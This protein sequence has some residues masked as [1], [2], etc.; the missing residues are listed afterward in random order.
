M[1]ND[2]INI[3]LSVGTLL[4]N[5]KYRI[6]K[7]LSSGGF[8]N[9]YVVTNLYFEEK[10]AMKE[11]FM[12]GINE[13]DE[14]N[15][16]ISISNS[17]NKTQFFSQLEKFKKEARR[18]RKLSNPHIVRVHDLFEENGTAY[19]IM[20]FIE[21]ESLSEMIKRTGKA[22]R[23]E[24]VTEILNQ[25]I[26]ALDDV[27]KIG[28]WHLDLK[29]AN[30]L[31][32]KLGKIL[33]ID[34]GA[35]KQISSDEGYTSTTT[36]MSYTRGYA[37]TEQ[38]EQR[39]DNIGP[40][41][42]FYALGATL[43]YLLT[44]NEPP[45]VSQL[46]DSDA[47]VFPQLISGRM[48]SLIR[49][50][51]QPNRRKRPQSVTEIRD[52][53]KNEEI[54]IE[55]NK[56]EESSEDTI[57]GNAQ[58][59]TNNKKRFV[60]SLFN[61]MITKLSLNKKNISS[62]HVLFFIISF[63]STVIIGGLLPH[64]CGRVAEMDA[65]TLSL[66]VD[67][68]TIGHEDA[69]PHNLLIDINYESALGK[70]NYIGPVD[71]NHKPHGDGEAT[72]IDGRFYRGPFEHGNFDGVDAYFRYDNGDTFEGSFVNNTFSKGKYTIKADGSYFIG[73]FKNGQPEKGTWYNIDGKVINQVGGEIPQSTF[74]YNNPISEKKN[75]IRG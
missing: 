36:S 52:F 44:R 34:F 56:A 19:Y 11:F 35:S 2:N 23:E 45:T 30:I 41:T 59:V 21:G 48:Q 3:M 5:G 74:K 63:L 61:G 70:C 38:I 68:D 31:Q 42:D 62:T 67:E 37:P 72:F 28:I 65:D 46:L 18:L 9:T 24:N 47:F 33:L 51:M 49:W 66:D 73:T 50:M 20:D 4:Q 60:D 26:D 7:Q 39:L 1:G 69:S 58:I 53:L 22:L 57:L 13:R 55:S 75:R 32:D 43:Y 27:H 10:F 25:I 54:N 12:R 29:P 17:D 71:E 64:N 16:S 14:D 40:W 8:G 6:D 15:T